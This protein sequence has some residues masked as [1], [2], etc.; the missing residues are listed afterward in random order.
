MVALF[1]AN[2]QLVILGFSK[3]LFKFQTEPLPD[4]VTKAN[5]MLRTVGLPDK[6]KN[7]Q[8]RKGRKHRKKPL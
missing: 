2:P 5:E 3:T 4:K 7:H 1:I 6:W 8:K